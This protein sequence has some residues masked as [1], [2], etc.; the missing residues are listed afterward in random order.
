MT[1]TEEVEKFLE[2]IPSYYNVPCPLLLQYASFNYTNLL[3]L[4]LIAEEVMEVNIT[5]PFTNKRQLVTAIKELHEHYYFHKIP[6]SWIRIEGKDAI[7]KKNN[8]PTL[9]ATRLRT[10][11]TRKRDQRH[12]NTY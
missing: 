2:K 5:T 10:Y 9:H 7:S 3:T 4:P 12:Y 8:I 1:T 11:L 6:E